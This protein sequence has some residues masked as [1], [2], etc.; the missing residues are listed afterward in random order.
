MHKRKIMHR[1]LKPENIIFIKPNSYE[2]SIADFG[3]ATRADLEKYLFIRCGTPGFVAPEVINIRDLNTTYDPICDVFSLGLIFH[4]LYSLSLLLII[5][6]TNF[7]D[8]KSFTL[9]YMIF[10]M[11]KKSKALNNNII[12]QYIYQF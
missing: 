7:I 1:D 12:K 6:L 8:E 10:P 4:I 5:N 2:V 9:I 11:N 3:L